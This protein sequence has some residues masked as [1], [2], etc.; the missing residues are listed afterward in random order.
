MCKDEMTRVK[1][2]LPVTPNVPAGVEDASKWICDSA[3]TDP[4]ACQGDGTCKLRKKMSQIYQAKY[5]T[6]RILRIAK[7]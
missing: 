7:P 6:K 3:Y 2:E 1:L 4:L 5:F